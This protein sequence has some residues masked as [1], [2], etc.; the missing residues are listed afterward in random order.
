MLFLSNTS[1]WFPFCTRRWSGLPLAGPHLCP[2][3][4]AE[5]PLLW[6]LELNKTTCF[7]HSREFGLCRLGDAFKKRNL[8][9]WMVLSTSRSSMPVSTRNWKAGCGWVSTDSTSWSWL[10]RCAASPASYTQCSF[11]VW[12]SLLSGYKIKVGRPTSWVPHS[13]ESSTSVGM[14]WSQLP[15]LSSSPAPPPFSSVS[16]RGGGQLECSS[17]LVCEKWL[18]L[19]V[20]SECRLGTTCC[21]GAGR[22]HD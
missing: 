14:A 15:P 8:M 18:L 5:L 7:L 2:K 4:K 3:M 20:N 13:V 16:V 12:P 19:Q 10:L 6:L 9:F 11:G 22:S 1:F 21:G 17:L